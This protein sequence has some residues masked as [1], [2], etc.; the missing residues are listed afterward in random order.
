MDHINIKPGK[1]IV[2]V[3]GGVDS[4]ALLDMLSRDPSLELIVAHFDHGIRSDSRADQEFVSKLAKKYQL[5]YEYGEGH[6]GENASEAAARRSRYEFLKEVQNKYKAMAIV[7]AHH[8]DD[9]IETIILNLLRGTGRKGLSSLKNTDSLVRPL[10]DFS[11]QQLKS[12]ALKHHLSWRED[13][14]NIDVKYLRNWIRLKLMPKL[15]TVSRQTLIDLYH[16]NKLQNAEIDN[17]LQSFIDSNQ[18]AQKDIINLDH[19]VAKELVAAWLRQN[20]I[21]FDKKTIERVVIGAKTLK[22]GK[23]IPISRQQFVKISDNMLLL[24]K[25]E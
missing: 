24:C 13:P 9:L 19:Q 3:S 5:V 22:K 14:T 16:K 21:S 12:Y 1:Y 15:T 2:A 17:L 10:L 8:Q 6:L 23:M 25:S 18:L 7:T 4:V 11:K 20:S